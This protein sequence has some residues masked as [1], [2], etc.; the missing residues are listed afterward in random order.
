MQ[1][2][3]EKKIKFISITIRL[4]IIEVLFWFIVHGF[5]QET[6]LSGVINFR[7]Q[8]IQCRKN[9]QHYPLTQQFAGITGF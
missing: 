7:F 4:S 8:N 2:L 3:L 9:R 5:V 1:S 6:N